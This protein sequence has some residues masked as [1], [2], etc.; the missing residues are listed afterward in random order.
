M[1]ISEK[2]TINDLMKEREDLL[3]KKRDC[4]DELLSIQIKR[5]LIAIVVAEYEY[6]KESE[7]EESIV[8][9][10]ALSNVISAIYRHEQKL[11]TKQ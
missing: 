11:E 8:A 7:V 4:A 3:K 6:W 5:E 1:D 9:M 10:G 2:R